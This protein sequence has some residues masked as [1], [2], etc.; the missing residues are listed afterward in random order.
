MRRMDR[1]LVQH[2]DEP[3]INLCLYG[4]LCIFGFQYMYDKSSSA[5]RHLSLFQMK[6]GQIDGCLVLPMQKTQW[7]CMCSSQG[8]SMVKNLLPRCWHNVTTFKLAFRTGIRQGTLE[9]VIEEVLW[10]I[11]ESYQT[12]HHLRL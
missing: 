10:S 3:A 5:H 2:M 11:R 9:I 8:V 4:F 12:S 7:D 6:C 1:G